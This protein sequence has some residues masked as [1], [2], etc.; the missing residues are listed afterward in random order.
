MKK[1]IAVAALILGATLNAHAADEAKP[2]RFLLGAGITAGG[3]KLGTTVQYS[4]GSAVD[5]NAGGLLALYAGMDYRYPNKV[6]VQAT[7]GYHV[8]DRSAKNGSVRFDR[9]P[10]EML[11][12]YG[13]TDQFR[14]GGGVRYV[15]NPKVSG[16][17]IASGTAYEF[18]STTGA[19]I[20]G[21]YFF[22]PTFG[23][24]IRAVSETY[25]PKNGGNSVNGNHGGAY[26]SFYF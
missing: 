16:S 19:I 12:Y 4:D 10:F 7:I 3:D 6:S 20:E 13:I 11:A 24:K 5:L 21:E 26:V 22:T 14:L 17:G 9:Y 25:K 8:D 1:Q 18:D 23:L 2:L 15:M